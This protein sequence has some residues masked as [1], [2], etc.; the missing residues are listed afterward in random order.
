MSKAI[1]I[2]ATGA[3]DVLRW[4]DVPKPEPGPGE[5]LVRHEAIGLNFIDIYFRTG[6]Y[7]LPGFP[8]IIGQEGAGI[9]EAIGADVPDL[10]P[11]DR[12]SYAG[13]LGAY[14]TH[15]VLPADRAIKLPP[16][17]D[18]RTA[19]AITLQGLTAQYLIHRTHVVQPGEKILV[20]A[21]AGGVGQ[22]L[23]QWASHLGATVIGVVSSAEKAEIARANGAAHAIVGIK[24]LA[25]DV[26]RITGGDMVPVVYDSVGKDSFH[27]S[28]DCLAPLGLMVSY[29]NA[30]GPVPPFELSLLSAKGSLFI[31]RPTLATY[32]SKRPVLERMAADL[33]EAVR[34]GVLKPHI[35]QT[36]PLA[37]AAAAH[38][39][40]EARQTTGQ[41]VLIP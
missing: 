38:T 32:T 4:E 8:A 12:I 31:T 1:R 6:L 9:I 40:L 34:T 10:A 26:K 18:S 33:F 22:L 2:H 25:A 30:S 11:G 29:G 16:D 15:R 27:A 5:I 41:V 14:A 3:P 7:K 35:T 17:I 21:A 20:H 13:S 39:A 24:T 23:C 19:A 36:F 37:E 28:L